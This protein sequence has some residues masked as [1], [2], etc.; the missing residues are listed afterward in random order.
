[1]NLQEHI[2]KVLR[3]ET[4]NIEFPFMDTKVIDDEGNP[5]VMYHGGS[6]S[7]GEFKGG[8]WFTTSKVDATYYAKQNDGIVTKAY[9]IIKN[10]LYTGHIKHLNIK[11]TQDMI[12][13]AKKRNLTIK[14]E[15]GNISFIEANAGVL[16]AL[17]I[18]KDGVIDIHQGEILDAVIFNNNQIILI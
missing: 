13:S 12:K 7:G 6:Y 8:G 2:R 5:L 9:L 18:G 11:Q 1:M 15:D 10:P 14:I 3:E 16:I 4:E 17:D